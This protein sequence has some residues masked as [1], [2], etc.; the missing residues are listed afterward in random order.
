LIGLSALSIKHIYVKSFLCAIKL[1]LINLDFGF[2]CSKALLIVLYD[3]K[4][5]WKG[6]KEKAQKK[7]REVKWDG[8]IVEKYN[9]II[10]M[11]VNNR[12]WCWG[13]HIRDTSGLVFG[14]WCMNFCCE[15]WGGVLVVSTTVLE[16]ETT[17]RERVNY[18]KQL[19]PC[20]IQYFDKTIRY[21]TSPLIWLLVNGVK[22]VW[23]FIN[24]NW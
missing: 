17:R 12:I 1:K 18:P 23:S 2:R 16:R 4:Q 21:R 6:K 20:V 7:M 22:H 8:K 13:S 10:L 19:C 24:D 14:A 15:L 11:H 5:S 9:M 3:V